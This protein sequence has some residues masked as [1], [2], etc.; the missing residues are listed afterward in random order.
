MGPTQ[1]RKPEQKEGSAVMTTR[2]E[3]YLAKAVRI[4]AQKE[5]RTVSQVIRMAVK[6]FVDEQ[7]NGGRR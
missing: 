5:E 3:P 7:S 1:T 4:L 6:R 2:L